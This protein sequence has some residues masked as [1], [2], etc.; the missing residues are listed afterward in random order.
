MKETWKPVV[1]YEGLYEVSDLGRVRSV[2]RV[3]RDGRKLTG[4]LLSPGRDKDGYLQ[5][6]LSVDGVRQMCKAHT[7][8]LNAFVGP[9][10]GQMC[11]HLNDVKEDNRLDNLVWG[12]SQENYDDYRK[13]RGQL[14]V[15]GYPGVYRSGKK[16]VARPII[17]GEKVYLGSFTCPL[18]A[19]KACQTLS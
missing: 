13:N 6:L 14:P 11:R 3:L 4:R 8:V 5:V 7:L 2:N 17:K 18:E 19:H 12:T 16:W 10:N 1:G 15:S 9:S